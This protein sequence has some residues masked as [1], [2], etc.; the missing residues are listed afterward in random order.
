MRTSRL[1][2]RIGGKLA[3][4][5]G[6][7][8]VLVAGMTANQLI[9][10]NS[11]DRLSADAAFRRVIVDDLLA[12]HL[13]LQRAQLAVRDLRLADTPDEIKTAYALSQR[14]Q[15]EVARHLDAA[16]RLVDRAE[17][18]D[19]M[20]KVIEL[21][22]A[23]GQA[24]ADLLKAG[25]DFSVLLDK[26]HDA[27]VAFTK[28][29][30]AMLA[31]PALAGL[32]NRQDVE[33]AL[34]AIEIRLEAAH[35]ASWRYAAKHEPAQQQTV[36]T[37]NAEIVDLIARARGLVGDADMSH[38]M[39]SL[40]ELAATLAKLHQE[41]SA[42]IG[43][44]ADIAAQRAMPISREA[45]Q[46]LT[47]AVEMARRLSEASDA[48]AGSERTAAG[49]LGIGLGF[50]VILVLIGS[51]AFSMLNIARPVRR[52]GE[53]LVAIANGNKAIDI[54][55]SHRGDEV[56]DNARAAVK[57][58]DNL[59]QIERME[60]EKQQSDAERAAR[61]REEMRRLA[62]EFHSAVGK[63]V[64]TV[65]SAATELE[66]AAGM[67]TQTA[68][69]TQRLSTAVSTA[70]GEA[71]TNVN[72]VASAAEELAASV[73]EIGRQVDESSRIAGE[74]VT[75][76]GETDVR[77]AA[78]S[79]AAG[80]IGDVVKLITAV[81]EQTNLLALNATIEAARAGA[82]GKGFAVV[83]QEVKALAAQTAKATD[84]IGTQI[85]A[86]QGA[87]QDS[88][89]AIRAIGS[90][91][92]RVSEIAGAIAAAVEEQGAAT[93]AIA[94]SVQQ[95]ARGS[96]EVADNIVSVSR[97]ATET[98][99]A[100]ARVLGSARALARESSHLKLEVEKFLANV[101]AA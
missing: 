93:Q 50:V 46:I 69:S 87:T 86:M 73:T 58:K 44:R 18:R 74:A 88:V 92:N 36:V 80:R 30:E 61:R 52:I 10:N 42:N 71:L 17:N 76:A 51:T 47:T 57:F 1:R 3:I 82:A 72:S 28:A 16:L 23:Y 43:L 95:A 41:I 63:I 96:A 22:R 62:D 29:I 70:S 39:D 38:G 81:A 97:G 48:R 66:T 27:T 55:Y 78:L 2:F 100:S 53:V 98:G 90:T 94:R 83:A 20:Q 25:E 31:S 75:Q 91:I 64:D 35:G 32:A 59:L 12:A 24:A 54:P 99:T 45:D 56:G 8:V 7:A 26:R 68:D 65:S 11:V 6:M 84:E 101:R 89:A 85:G 34:N 77:I 9:S 37:R 60:A 4:I 79:Q 5:T 13:D 33:R 19:R 67:L 49:R 14:Q 15:N 21:N 40:R